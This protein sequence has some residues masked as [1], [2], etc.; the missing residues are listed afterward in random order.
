DFKNTIIIMTSNMGSRDYQ[1]SGFG[2]GEKSNKKDYDEVKKRVMGRVVNKFSPELINRIDETVIFKPLNEKSILKII[3]LQLAELI[4][5]LN[6]QKIKL[7]MTALAKKLLV[8]KGYDEQYGVRPLRREI[9]LSLE[10][11]ISELLLEN[12]V[13]SGQT[14]KVA[15]LSNAFTFK[16]TTSRK[17]KKIATK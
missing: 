3:D 9:Q 12:K 6:S 11:K 5:N 14:I 13:Q 1:G 8:K 17:K 10:D 4:T 15:T 16:I 7:H 2:F